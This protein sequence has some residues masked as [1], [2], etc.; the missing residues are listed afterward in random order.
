MIGKQTLLIKVTSN[1]MNGKPLPFPYR[2]RSNGRELRNPHFELQNHTLET[3]TLNNQVERDH[4]TQD[5]KIFRKKS[6]YNNNNT[7]SSNYRPQ[8]HNY[9]RDK[10][11]SRLIFSRN[12]LRIV[13]NFINSH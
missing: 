6:N 13:R 9:N 12:R 10:N 8:A 3:V 5:Y 2:S 1:N 7:Y 4:H 11:R